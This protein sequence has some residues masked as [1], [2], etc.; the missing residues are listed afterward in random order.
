MCTYSGQHTSQKWTQKQGRI[1]RFG[2]HIQCVCIYSVNNRANIDLNMG[3]F[4]PNRCK[5]TVEKVACPEKVH[6]DGFL[7][8]VGLQQRVR[9]D[10]RLLRPLAP[11][12]GQQARPVITR[13]L[14]ENLWKSQ[15]TGGLVVNS[16]ELTT[17]CA[18][19]C[20]LSSSIS[21]RPA[22]ARAVRVFT[23]N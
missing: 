18:Q 7:E 17:A 13:N 12:P 4:S 22:C 15:A 2:L 16:G 19:A 23:E 1:E 8:L 10:A 14:S 9:L 11:H 21:Q 20:S 6:A 5:R 3:L